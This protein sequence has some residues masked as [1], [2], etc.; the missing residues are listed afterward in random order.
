MMEVNL[1]KHW[2]VSRCCGR[3]F[4]EKSEAYVSAAREVSQPKFIAYFFCKAPMA[5]KKI[6]VVTTFYE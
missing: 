5:G 4:A 1:Q 3:K 6:I 2:Y